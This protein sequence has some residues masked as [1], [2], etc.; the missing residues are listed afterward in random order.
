MSRFRRPRVRGQGL[1]EFALV[2]PVFIV[3]VFA[4]FDVGRA[5]FAYN[6]LTNAAREGARL[7]MVN[8][9]V[10]KIEERIHGQSTGT[11]V[12]QC[13]YFIEAD[14]ANPFLT[15]GKNTITPAM[16]KD[17]GPP[18]RDTPADEC[19][20]ALKV[21]CIAHVEVWTDYAPITPLVSNIIGSMTLTANSEEPIEFVCPNPAIAEWDTPDECPKKP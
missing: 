6:E 2:F 10:P 20:A 15:C 21:G 4:L 11:T 19:P 8:Q 14:S 13:I 3:L 7:A 16:Q 5:V 17:P 12:D 9:S 1:V 18:P